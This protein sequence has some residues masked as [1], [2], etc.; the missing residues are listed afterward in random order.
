M[1]FADETVTG[2][3]GKDNIFKIPI[4]QRSYSWGKEQW[5]TFLEDIKTQITSDNKYSLGN[6]LLEKSEK[7]EQFYIID[8]QQRIT[9]LIIFMRAMINILKERKYSDETTFA[10]LNR[11]FIKNEFGYAKLETTNFDKACF[12][13]VIINNNDD[14]RADTPSQEQIIEAKKYFIKELRKEIEIDN[15]INIKEV[16]LNA[17]IVVITIEG[18][19]E[20]ALTFE[21]QNNRGL[22][23]TNMEKLKSYF[24]YQAYIF[25]NAKETDSNI[26]NISTYFEEIYKIIFDIRPLDEDTLLLYHN[27]TYLPKSYSSNGLEDI[28]DRKFDSC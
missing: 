21:L 1:K 14:Y 26:S 5:E 2:Y 9:T 23:L 12:N 7:E 25:S 28:K 20:A 15:L 13:T 19:K 3:F 24:M 4:Y 27:H 6:I 22:K 16:L 10:R 8:G 17:N 11:F 18:K